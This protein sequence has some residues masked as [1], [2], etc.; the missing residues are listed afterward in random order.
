VARKR[1]VRKYP[2]L[3][4]CRQALAALTPVLAEDV[5]FG[6]I[7]FFPPPGAAMAHCE[8]RSCERFIFPQYY[9]QGGC[10]DDCRA[11]FSLVAAQALEE[12]ERRREDGT[13]EPIERRAPKFERVDVDDEDLD[14][15]RETARRR[16]LTAHSQV[17][18][19]RLGR[20]RQVV[21]DQDD[22]GGQEFATIA[23]LADKSNVVFPEPDP[24]TPAPGA[25]GTPK[26]RAAA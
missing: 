20:L 6:R 16:V 3:L 1:K 17:L 10:C 9:V 15:Q 23:L 11:I 12:Y 8:R 25:G 14:P 22:R 2:D 21:S 13:L 18:V 19:C 4:S 26:P 24:G 7:A 5:R